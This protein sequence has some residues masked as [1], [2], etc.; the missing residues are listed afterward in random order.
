MNNVLDIVNK[1]GNIL[2]SVK[3]VVSKTTRFPDDGIHCFLNHPSLRNILAL[4]L[5]VFQDNNLF[6]SIRANHN[7]LKIKGVTTENDF[8]VNLL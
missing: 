4:T 1:V 5:F 8:A 2:G 3:S 6:Y 7:D